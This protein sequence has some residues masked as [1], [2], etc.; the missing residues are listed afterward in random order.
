MRKADLGFHKNA[1]LVDAGKIVK[2]ATDAVAKMVP[3]KP[4]E[5]GN[6]EQVGIKMPTMP[7]TPSMPDV[8]QITS[9]AVSTARGAVK[10]A[11]AGM[12]DRMPRMPKGPRMPRTPRS[13]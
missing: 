6:F 1:G 7:K 4:L 2:T 11:M 3:Q 5:P 9:S 13:Y 12:R 8:K 10:S